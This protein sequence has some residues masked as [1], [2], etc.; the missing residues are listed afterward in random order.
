MPAGT[1]SLGNFPGPADP[2]D[3]LGNRPASVAD[4]RECGSVLGAKSAHAP[5]GTAVA[6]WKDVCEMSFLGP[7]LDSS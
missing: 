3:A 1:A 7:T 6:L 5:R 4:Q 2:R